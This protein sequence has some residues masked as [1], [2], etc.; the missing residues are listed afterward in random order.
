MLLVG[1]TGSC[2]GCARTGCVTSAIATVAARVNLAAADRRSLPQDFK[3]T[4]RLTQVDPPGKET[5]NPSACRW[6][7]LV[8][9]QMNAVA[10]TAVGLLGAAVLG[11]FGSFF[12]LGKKIDALGARLDSRIDALAARMDDHLGRH[13]G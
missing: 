4:S 5:E 2:L 7:V 13:A 6:P 9:G 3:V 1:R 10:W 8:S 12:S 11:S